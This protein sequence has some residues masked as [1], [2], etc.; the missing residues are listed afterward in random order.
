MKCEEFIKNLSFIEKNTIGTFFSFSG[1]FDE[2]KFSY[3]FELAELLNSTQNHKEE[4]LKE[5][6]IV[7]AGLVLSAIYVAKKLHGKSEKLQYIEE[8]IR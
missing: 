1:V 3:S 7:P 8:K 6:N 5:L 2:E 4:I